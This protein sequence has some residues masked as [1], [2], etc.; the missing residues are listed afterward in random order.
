MESKNYLKLLLAIIALAIFPSKKVIA[1]ADCSAQASFSLPSSEIY[2]GTTLAFENQSENANNYEWY[3]NDV[4]VSGEEQF[5]Y[6]FNASGIFTV[7]LKAINVEENCFSQLS[8][9][10]TVTR[11]LGDRVDGVSNSFP[12]QDADEFGNAIENKAFDRFG[13]AYGLKDL[14]IPNHSVIAGIFMLH[15]YDDDNNTGVGFDDATLGTARRNVVTQVFEDISALLMPTWNSLTPSPYTGTYYVEIDVRSNSTPNGNP[16]P[17]GALGVASQYYLDYGTGITY[18]EVWKTI[19][20]GMNSYHGVIPQPSYHGYVAINFQGIN[21]YTNLSSTAIGGSQYDLY[22]VTLHEALHALGFASLIGQSGTGSNGRYS[23]YDTYLKFGT[24]SLIGNQ[25]SCYGQNFA[26]SIA[27]LVAGCNTVSFDGTGF[28]QDVHTP[29]TWANGSSL[30][31]FNCING[32]ACTLAGNG[33][34]MNFCSDVGVTQRYPHCRERQTLADLGYNVQ[35][36]YGN[37]DY[38]VST[39]TYSS[40]PVSPVTIAG[41]NDYNQYNAANNNAPFTVVSNGSSITLIDFTSGSTPGILNNDNNAIEFSCVEVVQGGSSSNISVNYGTQTIVYT[42]PLNLVG[43][44]ILKYR[45]KHSSGKLGNVTYI[46]IQVTAPCNPT[47]CNLVCFGDFENFAT[48]SNSLPLANIDLDHKISGS[49]NNSPDIVSNGSNQA[50]AIACNSSN[51]EAL[52]FHLKK[53]IPPGCI[54]NIKFKASYMVSGGTVPNGKIQIQGSDVPPCPQS[55]NNESSNTCGSNTLQCLLYTPTC[56]VTLNLFNTATFSGNWLSPINYNF[57]SYSIPYTNNTLNPIEWVVVNGGNSFPGSSFLYFD[58]FEITDSCQEQYTVTPTYSPTTPCPGGQVSISY[59]ICFQ[60]GGP[61]NSDTIFIGVDTTLSS[62]L[63]HAGGGNFN[64]QG[65]A[66]ILP[67]ALTTLSPCTTMVANVNINPNAPPGLPIQVNLNVDSDSACITSSANNP[68]LY[69]TPGPDSTLHINKV[70]VPPGPYEAGDTVEYKLVICNSSLNSSVTNIYISDTVP[71]QFLS[72]TINSGNMSVSGNILTAGPLSL[73]PGMCDTLSYTVELDTGICGWV[74]N[75]A[76]IDSAEGV[77]SYVDSGC[78]DIFVYSSQPAPVAG[79]DTGYCFSFPMDSMYATGNGCTLY[80]FHDSIHPSTF[81]DSGS[82]LLPPFTAPG[83][84]E[85]LVIDSCNGC[86][87]LPD[88]VTITIYSPPSIGPAGPFCVTDPPTLIP[89]SPTGGTFVSG[90]PGSVDQSGFFYPSIAGAG[91]HSIGYIYTDPNTGCTN[92]VNINITVLAPPVIQIPSQPIC[93]GSPPFNLQASQPGGV[94]GGPAIVNSATGLFDPSLASIGPNMVTYY[95]PGYICADSSDTAYINVFPNNWQQVA[96]S[97]AAS[98]VQ[99]EGLDTKTD[100]DGNVYVTG[101]CNPGAQFGTSTFLSGPGFLAKYDPCGDLIWAVDLPNPGMALAIHDGVRVYVAGGGQS[102]AFIEAYDPGTGGNIFST[103]MPHSG[104]YAH[105]RSMVLNHNN[106]PFVTGTFSNGSLFFPGWGT[107]NPSSPTNTE[108]FVAR[109]DPTAISWLNVRHITTPLANGYVEGSGI[110]IKPNTNRVYVVGNYNNMVDFGGISQSQS[111]YNSYL[112]R[113]NGAL[114]PLNSRT[115]T[116]YV[117]NAVEAEFRTFYTAGEVIVQGNL[118]VGS[119]WGGNLLNNWSTAAPVNES[120]FDVHLDKIED[121]IYVTGADFSSLSAVVVREIDP[122]NGSLGWAEFSTFGMGNAKDYGKGVTT[123][124]G[125]DF[126]YATGSY[127]GHIFFGTTTNHISNGGGTSDDIFT[128]RV[129][130]GTSSF[131]KSAPIPPTTPPADPQT[132][133]NGV[134]VYPNTSTGEFTIEFINDENDKTTKINMTS[135]TGQTIISKEYP[136]VKG[137][138][139]LKLDATSVSSGMYFIN[140]SV[141]GNTSSH[142]VVIS[143]Q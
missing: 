76:Y 5:S 109:F 68:P 96:G 135:I 24:T 111:G 124:D 38:A 61:S 45:P 23:I 138:N 125:G 75:C 59:T 7:T 84:Y 32:G 131:A 106:I 115:I 30:S 90:I 17:T 143:K 98:G 6:Y 10:I 41:I 21:W 119:F 55:S 82:S 137:L 33:Y 99:E 142:K 122:S 127:T 34:S 20:T 25:S 85:Y 27:N 91:L 43:N 94:W 112:V 92:R 116:N 89:H 87:S 49:P 81:I 118:D 132:V 70:A 66:M 13:N 134:I 48:G 141:N 28:T 139:K 47:T 42:P 63:S 88:T 51:P 16:M 80:W 104:S 130:K 67:G 26:T 62:Y 73:G 117:P 4:V 101:S 58:D 74:T 72:G 44:A 2:M 8:K 64:N 103:I 52:L 29:T 133:A 95:I 71:P 69:I 123:F 113:Y 102:I 9:E 35:S 1:Q 110:T 12:A 65:Q 107:L 36:T 15:F 126:V 14:E 39:H 77:C 100:K 22:T 19:K 97:P 105:I 46:F 3:V 37:G 114:N 78:T 54:A 136:V 128:C 140:L 40:C 83:T 11:N 129:H 56:M 121:K 60:G 31:H 108:A 18:G 57:V 53:P 86:P 93:W 79:K 50:A 120:Y